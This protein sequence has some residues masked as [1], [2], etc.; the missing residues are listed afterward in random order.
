[1]SA[2]VQVC[3]ST[4]TKQNVI[5][6]QYTLCVCSCICSVDMDYSIFYSSQQLDCKG[7]PLDN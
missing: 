1:M 3:L 7:Q 6:A 4:Y 2:C 5:H